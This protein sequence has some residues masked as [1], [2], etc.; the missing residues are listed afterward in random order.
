[1]ESTLMV[2][3]LEEKIPLKKDA[4]L[5]KDQGT[6]PEMPD[7]E[8]EMEMLRQIIRG[9]VRSGDVYTRYSRNQYLVLLTG[10]KEADGQKVARRLEKQWKE[11]GG[12]GRSEASF[13]VYTVEGSGTEGCMDAEERDICSACDQP[14]KR[15]MAGAGNLAG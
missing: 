4:A 3:A 7:I 1:M 5:S 15:H 11:T 9:G 8:P 13:T 6:A 12:D 14:G 10:A 2:A